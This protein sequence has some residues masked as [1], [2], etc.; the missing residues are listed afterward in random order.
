MVLNLEQSFIKE[1]L[2]IIQKD[3]PFHS[4]PFLEIAKR[5]R[6]TEEEVLNFLL[7][8]KRKK[9]LR[10]ISAIF[11]PSVFKH[12]SA[13]FAFKVS[14]KNL[15]QA[16]KVVNSHPGVTHNYLRNHQYNLWFT[17]VVLPGEDILKVASELFY[18]SRA[19]DF[20]YL[21]VVKTFKISTILEVE[22]SDELEVDKNS[23]EIFIDLDF[24]EKDIKLVKHLQEPLPL[25][26]T[27]FAIVSKACGVDEET[28]F[29][30]LKKM[31][32]LKA[33]RRFG[34]LLDRKHFGYAK[35]IMVLWE[36]PEEETSEI[37]KVLS[38]KDFITHC[39]ERKTYS[40]WRYNLYTMCHFKTEEEKKIIP[41]LAERLKIKNYLML[42]TLKELKKERL[43]L[44]YKVT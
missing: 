41:L 42:E 13:L 4:R 27:P 30:W 8:L 19:E 44:F 10:Q 22:N 32:R 23:N 9:Y 18:L 26:S 12:S 40:Y 25:V 21:P 5:L 39:Y 14:K 16:I 15:A 43:K 33:L 34:A 2:K 31:S 6:I 36:V 28:I 17:L 38:K 1:L 29:S 24:T 7:E 3:F 11:N 35:N 20:L 37:G